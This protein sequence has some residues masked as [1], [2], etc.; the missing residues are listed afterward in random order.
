[1]SKKETVSKKSI[2]QT[3]QKKPF[4]AMK[5]LLFLLLGAVVF[6]AGVYVGKV[7]LR[8]NSDGG[9]YTL[10]GDFSEKSG[11]VNVN[12]LWE[13]WN[14]LES[15]YINKNLDGQK[16]L[17][18][19][20]RGLVESLDDPYTFF[21]SP[22]ETEDYLKGNA[23][24]FEGIGTT[25]RY[26]GEYTV[27]ESPIDGYPARNA[28]LEPGDAILEVDGE[29]MRNKSAAYVAS[30]I[31]G[32]AGTTVKLKVF[33]I[34]SQ[35]EEEFEIKREKI[36]LDNVTFKDLGNGY[37]EIKIIKFTEEN[38]AAFNQQWDSVIQSVLSKN[39]KGIVI[40]LR[41]NPGGYVDS[42]KYSVSEFLEKGK[43]I[44]SEENRDGD[45]TVHKVERTGLLKNIPIVVL[46]NE[47]TASASEIFA[48][49][50]QDNGRAKVVGMKTVG[51]GVEQR[52][53]ELDDGS[54]I[55]VVFRKWL[56]P[57]EKNI[58]KDSP[59]VPDYEVDYSMEDF[60]KGLDPQLEK[61]L[62]LIK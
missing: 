55:H 19:A 3:G 27:I 20:V 7:D 18:G 13:A 42:A 31:R 61:G 60:N 28:G 34:S 39:P 40:D 37:V 51:K 49:A 24:A 58:S 33:K 21:L 12:L 29:A 59:I 48:G 4:P 9:N 17:Y 46:V 43:T 14:Q 56:T 25:L 1:M 47:G 15:V 36:D 26:N 38:V 53:V 23:S 62:E 30:K 2:I 11:E 16:L 6:V 5:L 35:R 22:D 52:I 45:R 54:S 57:N 44:L 41:N 50:L 32:T 10:T 8:K